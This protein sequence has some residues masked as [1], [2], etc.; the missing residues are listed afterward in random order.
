MIMSYE[1]FYTTTVGS[2]TEGYPAYTAGLRPGD[3][4]EKLNGENVSSYNDFSFKMQ[5]TEH[6]LITREKKTNTN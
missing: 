2:V 4:I 1:G 5:S 6:K 3:K